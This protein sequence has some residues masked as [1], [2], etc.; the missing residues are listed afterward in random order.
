M[1]KSL[2]VNLLKLIGQVGTLN[3]Y[4]VLSAKYKG[5]FRRGLNWR[6]LIVCIKPPIMCF[7]M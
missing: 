5:S 4:V 7:R 1:N 3:T 6:I 2:S